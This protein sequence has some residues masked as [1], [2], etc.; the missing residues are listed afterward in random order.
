MRVSTPQDSR[1]PL[2]NKNAAVRQQLQQPAIR[3][4]TRMTMT[5]EAAAGSRPQQRRF[6]LI[7]VR[8]Y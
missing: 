8:N 1:D 6:A 3:R 2:S 7:E 5:P 4:K